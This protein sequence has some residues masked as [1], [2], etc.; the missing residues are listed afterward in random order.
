MKTNPKLKTMCRNPY[1][2]HYFGE[3]KIISNANLWEGYFENQTITQDSK[4]TY[5]G[6]LDN[7]KNIF[8]YGFA[9]YPSTYKL[10][11]FLQ[12]ILI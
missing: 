8:H 9:V 2:H 12:K 4:I 10:L 1:K 7:K 5:T 3:H 6:I 11:D